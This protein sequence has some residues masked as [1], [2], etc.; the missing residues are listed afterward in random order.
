MPFMHVQAETFHRSNF[1]SFASL[2]ATFV[3]ASTAIDPA[4]RWV[5]C[6]WVKFY[7]KSHFSIFIGAR[8]KP[9]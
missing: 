1:G 6:V 9:T 3:S 7:Q 2:H 5:G 4:F 8:A